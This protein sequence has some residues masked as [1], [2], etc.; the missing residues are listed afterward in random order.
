[1]LAR[2]GDDLVRVVAGVGQ[3]RLRVAPRPRGAPPL[4]ARVSAASRSSACSARA[5]ASATS[6]CIS[7]CTS[8]LRRVSS[9]S[10]SSRFLAISICRS[11][12][13]RRASSR[14]ASASAWAAE[15]SS[16]AASPR[17]STTCARRL[18]ASGLE[19]CRGVA[20]GVLRAASTAV[21]VAASNAAVAFALSVA[22]CSSVSARSGAV[23][24]SALARS[25]AVSRCG[26]VARLGNLGVDGRTQLLRVALCLLEGVGRRARRRTR[27]ERRGPCARAA[28]AP[29][30]LA[31]RCEC[32]LVLGLALAMSVAAWLGRLAP[33][34]LCANE[35][36][37]RPPAASWQRVRRARRRRCRSALC[38]R[39]RVVSLRS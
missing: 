17:A 10:A 35:L 27:R 16:A 13:S 14:T 5:W 29:R 21:A 37:V 23:S 34:A 11:S 3:Q 26:R 32:R 25:S 15:R 19:G 28:A 2:L 12:R 39:G 31:R 36:V 8:S 1:M 30:G 24:A 20:L 9:R 33:P 4:R 22:T 7:A 38:A 6:A 18:V